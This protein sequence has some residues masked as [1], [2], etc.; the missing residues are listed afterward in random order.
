MS[1]PDIIRKCAKIKAAVMNTAVFKAIQEE[2]DFFNA[3]ISG[4][5]PGESILDYK[6]TTSEISDAFSADLRKRGMKFVGSI[7]IHAFLQAIGI[8]NSHQ[9]ASSHHIQKKCPS[10]SS[11]TPL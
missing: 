9:P 6:S 8:F 10:H 7:T 2:L 1:I 5:C 11:G 3:Y 4:F